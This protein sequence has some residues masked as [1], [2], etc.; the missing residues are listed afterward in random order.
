MNTAYK[1]CLAYLHAQLPMYQRQ[2]ANAF[3][4][5]LSNIKALCKF[6]EHPE[7]KFKSIHIAGSNGKGSVSHML[8]SILQSAG[9]KTGLYTSPHLIDFRER[10]K[11][12][13]KMI[14]E[15]SVVNFTNR[16]R[17]ELED[18]KPSFFEITVALAF[19]HFAAEEVDFAI[20]ETGLGGRLDSTNILMP[21]LSIITNISLEH[22]QMLGDSLEE[23]ATEKAGIIK[24]GIPLIVG[25]TQA[26]SRNV[27][28]ATA[29][30]K[31]SRTRY[32]DKIY[33]TTLISSH[34]DE[35][36]FFV[37][38]NGK[39]YIDKLC[40][41]LPALYQME[42]ACT[43]LCAI[44]ELNRQGLGVEM[45]HVISGLETT[46]SKTGLKGRWQVISRNPLVIC[47]T[48]HN[49]DGFKKVLKMLEGQKARHK[50][51]VLG[52][53]DDKDINNALAVFP[54]DAFYYFTQAD[55]PRAMKL[56]LIISAAEKLGLKYNSSKSVSE[57]VTLALQKVDNEDV[58]YIGGS[59]FVVADY[60]KT[61]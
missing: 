56:D 49:V 11:I 48:A 46:A 28:D 36:C 5:D 23:I 44:Q 10:I 52:F 35:L 2:G 6:L 40:L 16:V 19:D 3:K 21:K 32:A 51:F 26:E 8:A 34:A 18:I 43:A 55:V 47:D 30:E 31:R 7:R 12:N 25:R 39:P 50:H 41:D 22:T 13:N 58:I 37:N 20:I 15:G 29:N 59:T 1:D 33:S 61:I 60:L 38:R 17:T 4:K 42:N 24:P 57:A 53:V 45:A 54:K 9:Y 27:F 14:P